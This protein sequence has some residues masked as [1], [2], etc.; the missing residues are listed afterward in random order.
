MKR[1]EFLIGSVLT[2]TGTSA[3]AQHKG[4]AYRLAVVD[5]FNPVAEFTEDS[6]PRR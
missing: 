3:R 5:T 1:R 2:A 4:K 6:E